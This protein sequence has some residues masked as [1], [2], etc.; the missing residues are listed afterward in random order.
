MSRLLEIGYDGDTRA[1][2]QHGSGAELERAFDGD[3]V[4]GPGKTRATGACQTVWPCIEMAS[5]SARERPDF[6]MTRDTARAYHSERPE[7]T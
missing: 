1:F 6:S 7:L 2:P 3:V 5:V 4:S